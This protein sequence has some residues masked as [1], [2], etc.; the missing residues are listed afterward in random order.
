MENRISSTNAALKVGSTAF[1]LS[2]W[3]DRSITMQKGCMI[4][5]S[6][7]QLMPQKIALSSEF[8]KLIG[9]F[10][11]EGHADFDEKKASYRISITNN[12][13]IFI[14]E[15]VNAWHNI[16]PNIKYSSINNDFQVDSKIAS[17][18]FLRMFGGNAQEKKLPDDIYSW[19]EE[20]VKALLRMYFE[21]DGWAVAEKTEIA[22]SSKSEKLIDDLQTVLL[23]FGILS[24]I[25]TLKR[26]KGIYYELKIIPK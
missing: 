3:R 14:R 11:S 18:L 26:K 12:D 19:P 7:K 9:A 20:T 13:A 10:I 5:K 8:G 21:G 1:T 2:N 22:C 25:R 17:A 24:R 15:T 6:L 23:G 16:F 4:A